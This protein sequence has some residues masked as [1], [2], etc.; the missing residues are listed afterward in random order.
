M[1][2]SMGENEVQLPL[3]HV[4]GSPG[5]VGYMTQIF[6]LTDGCVRLKYIFFLKKNSSLKMHKGITRF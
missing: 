3:L 5:I 1:D 2:A 4:Y 6:L